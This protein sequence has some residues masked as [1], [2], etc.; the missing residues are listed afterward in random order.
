MVEYAKGKS[1]YGF[2]ERC[3]LRYALA[4]FKSEYVKGVEKKNRVCH[5]CWD[6]D[7][8][9]N[10]VGTFKVSDPQALRRPVPEIGADSINAFPTVTAELRGLYVAT[11]IGR[12]TITS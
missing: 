8:P 10:F 1:A 3:G 6:A 9:Q 11:V 7:H 4:D 12:V 5:E 2:C